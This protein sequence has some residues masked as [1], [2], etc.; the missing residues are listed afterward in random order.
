MN[1]HTIDFIY[2]LNL[3]RHVERLEAS[4]GKLLDVGFPPEIIRTYHGPD[5][6]DYASTAEVIEAASYEFPLFKTFFRI[7]NRSEF[8]GLMAQTY[9]YL[10]F[11]KKVAEYPDHYN[12]AAIQDRRQL[13]ITYKALCDD[14]RDLRSLDPDF[15][16]LIGIGFVN[17]TESFSDET[18]P[19]EYDQINKDIRGSCGDWFQIISPRNAQNIID[20]Y[21]SCMNA[22]KCLNE[23]HFT[24]ESFYIYHL[25]KD[26]AY[27][28]NGGIVGHIQGIDKFPSNLHYE[29]VIDE[30]N[31]DNNMGLIDYSKIERS[32]K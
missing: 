22:S 4:R 28:H 15:W 16:V 6:I 23:E 31:V 30:W 20:S 8:Q 32:G 19:T 2:I 12:I 5:I 29:K 3:S 27:T 9:G 13:H 11:L 25:P 17:E 14:I 10:K 24:L 7:A 21:L 18:L 26:H 1:H